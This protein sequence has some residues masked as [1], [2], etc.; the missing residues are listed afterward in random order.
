MSDVEVT[1]KNRTEL[2]MEELEK[3]LDRISI[4][5]SDVLNALKGSEL[6]GEGLIKRHV[7]VE[8]RVTEIE[9]TI[10]RVKWIAFGWGAGAGI[11]V[12]GSIIGLFKLITGI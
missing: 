3:K 8:A 6:L 11:G 7:N 12:A 2:L 9:K 4:D 1:E 5:V 10:S